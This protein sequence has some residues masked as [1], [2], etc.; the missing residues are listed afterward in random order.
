MRIVILV[1]MSL[2]LGC[3]GQITA[4][5]AWAQPIYLEGDLSG[6]TRTD[7]LAIINHNDKYKELCK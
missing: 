4:E 2:T 6:L 1:M 5:C 3:A 7:K